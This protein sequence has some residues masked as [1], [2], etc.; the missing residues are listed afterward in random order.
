V[1]TKQCYK[2]K[3]YLS[4][5]FF[6]KNRKS[7]DGYKN[8]CKECSR[9][10]LREY[11]KKNPDKVKKNRK[12]NYQKNS[13]KFRARA[14]EWSKDNKSKKSEI[15][16]KWYE[17]NKKNHLEKKK[18]IRKTE[19]YRKKARE[20]YKKNEIITL[21]FVVSSHIRN[22]LKRNG[23]SKNGQSILDRLPYTLQQLKEHL[24]NQFE[25]WMNWENHGSYK[26]D[27]ERV[28]HIDHIIPQYEL[29][30]DSYEHE[31]FL[32]CWD[33]KNLRPLEASLNLKKGSK[34]EERGENE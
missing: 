11:R 5:E 13:E 12:E 23:G 22:A 30:Y 7:K 9:D 25:P 31:N 18:K 19:I 10:I 34:L 4:Y 29:P 26:I 33:L 15:F 8:S 28:W 2:C 27:E 6:Y 24:E 1:E 17:K 21:K 3:K 14:R 20:Y 32:K 16:K